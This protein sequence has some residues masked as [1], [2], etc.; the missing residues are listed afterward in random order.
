MHQH[1]VMADASRCSRE[2]CRRCID[3]DEFGWQ[4]LRSQTLQEETGA[5]S[6]IQNPL[7]RLGIEEAPDVLM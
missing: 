4:R 6:D 7:V 1:R 3:A 5:T 2:H